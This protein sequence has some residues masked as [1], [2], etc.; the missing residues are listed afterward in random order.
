MSN[1]GFG[2][3]ALHGLLHMIIRIPAGLLLL[4]SIVWLLGSDLASAQM[5][6]VEVVVDRGLGRG[7]PGSFM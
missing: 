3:T 6:L 5:A 4:F 7:N 2:R 1:R